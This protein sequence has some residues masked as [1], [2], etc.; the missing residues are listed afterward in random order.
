MYVYTQSHYMYVLIH[1]LISESATCAELP[2]VQ[3]GHVIVAEP[4]CD[5]LISIRL[6]G[7][8]EHHSTW[9]LDTWKIDDTKHG[10]NL[11]YRDL[12]MFN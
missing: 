2:S 12:T 8:P 9:Y 5:I 3:L 4:S 1:I 7:C 11:T 10:P 6:V